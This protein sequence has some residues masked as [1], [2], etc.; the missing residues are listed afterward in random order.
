MN[1]S[2]NAVS[3]LG[4][5]GLAVFL[6]AAAAS[7]IFLLLLFPLLR[8]HAMARPNTRSSHRMPT[9][10]G[11]GIAVIGATTLVTGG[12]F[13]FAGVFLHEPLRLAIIIASVV[14]L[15]VVGMTDD[16]RPLEALPRLALQAIAGAIVVATL[17]ADLHVISMLPW[18][19]ERAL[20][21]VGILWF[22]NLVNFMDGLDWIVIAEVVPITAAL[23]LFGVWGALPRDATLISLALCGAMVGFA[24]FNRP[25]A[26]LFLGDVGSLPVGLLVAWLLIELGQR[27]LVAAVLLPLYFVAD[28]TI[29]LLLRLIQGEPVMQAHRS[30]FYQRAFDAGLG[31]YSIVARVFV[32]NVALIGLSAVAVLTSSRPL[33]L[34]YLAIGC[35]LVAWLLIFFANQE[36]ESP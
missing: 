3:W 18:W 28:A 29:T 2:G 30:H 10:Q 1:D 4:A 36:N 6:A 25:I 11:G 35:A 16:V 33:Q 22:V 13:A 20:M 31:I 15:A 7:F 8:R 27:H 21:I 19:T 12:I 5:V 23:A 14:G 17:P 34:A 32:L 24:P 26:R 9:P